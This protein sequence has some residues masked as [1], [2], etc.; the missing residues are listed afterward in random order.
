M[1]L[2]RFGTQRGHRLV[3]LIEIVSPSNKR[4]GVDRR[5]YLMKQREVLDSDA[6]LIELDLLRDGERL[7]A[8][9]LLVD[10]VAHLEPG[11]IIWCWST[12]PGCGLG[13]RPPIRSFRCW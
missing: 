1:P 12:G 10:T 7:L 11:P 4:P 2:S 3:T 6:N 9:L 8:N 5:A 13:T